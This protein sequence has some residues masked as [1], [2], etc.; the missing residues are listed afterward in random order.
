MAMSKATARELNGAPFLLEFLASKQRKTLVNL[1]KAVENTAA[2]LLHFYV[3]EGLPVN[4][5]PLWSNRELEIANSKGNHALACTP[6]IIRFIY[7]GWGGRVED[8]GYL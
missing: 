4:T 3:E 1:P 7:R 6:E 8:K 2:S 5:E